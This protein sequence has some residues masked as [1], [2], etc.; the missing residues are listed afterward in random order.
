MMT[1]LKI[2]VFFKTLR[3]AWLVGRLYFGLTLPERAKFLAKMRTT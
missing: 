1:Y 3:T 2:K